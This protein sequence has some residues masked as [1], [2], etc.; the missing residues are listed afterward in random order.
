MSLLK[1]RFF[2]FF[3]CLAL[4]LFPAL[5]AF[6]DT[7]VTHESAV[8]TC[9]GFSIDCSDKA[10]TVTPLSAKGS[11][12]LLVRL[13]NT[14]GSVCA[15]KA[16][17]R[18]SGVSLST[19]ALK[20]G[21]YYVELFTGKTATGEYESYASGKSTLLITVKSGIPSRVISES[22][23]ENLKLFSQNRT[24]A[25]AL[26]Y[27]KTASAEIQSGNQTLSALAKQ[28]TADKESTLLKIK[29]IHDWTAGYLYYDYDGTSAASDAVTAFQTQVGDEASYANLTAALLRAAD[30][31][32]KVVYGYA[33]TD[34][35]EALTDLGKKEENHCWNE[36]YDA[37]LGRWVIL[38]TCW[39]SGN[40]L[41]SGKRITG[42]G[43]SRYFDPTLEAF[44]FDHLLMRQEDT[45]GLAAYFKTEVKKVEVTL[46]R[47]YAFT[48]TLYHTAKVQVTLP[49]SLADAKLTY[50]SSNKTIASI[51]KAGTVT[52]NAAGTV[53]LGVKVSDGVSSYTFKKSFK[54]YRPFLKYTTSVSSLKVG[55]SYTFAVKKYG[56]SGTVKW[57]VSNTKYATINSKGKL[58]AKRSGTVTVTATVNGVKKSIKVT[59]KK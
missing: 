47:A 4:G 8:D 29:A 1:K 26:S 55:K 23:A 13:T 27:Y 36:A 33:E 19:A 14:S 12:Y 58:T 10:V 48:E 31:P 28:L 24:D 35:S 3:L 15:E 17:S 39:D 49:D 40:S 34:T 11:G 38:D 9:D 20:D 5:P 16:A 56:V 37:E 51:T 59:I 22:W 53:T 21:N 45:D 2:C 54:V 44:S 25:L 50:A 6:A 46:N 57:S 52:G 41:L 18:K 43:F 30:I 32:A 7:F 42:S